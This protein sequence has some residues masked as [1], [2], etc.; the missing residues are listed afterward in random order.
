MLGLMQYEQMMI[1]DFIVHA[2]RH[3]ARAE[4]VSRLAEGIHRQTYRDTELRAR[5][6]AQALG[7]LDV[8]PGDRVATLAW[9]TYRHLELYFA[10]SGSAAVVNTVNPRLAPEDIA[11]ILG[12]AED[13]VLFAEVEFAP[14][15]ADVA[16]RLPAG[17]LRTVVFLC[18][19]H[20]LPRV[21]LPGGIDVMAY[22][23]LVDAEDGDYAWPR[24]DERS[25]SALCYTSGTTGRPKGVL[26]T[27]RSTTLKAMAMNAADAAGLRA[28]DR[29]MPAVPM[30]HVNAWSL[31][32]AA[33]IAGTALV[34]PGRFLD[35]ASLYRLI[36][37]ERVTF[38]CGVP[39]VWLGVLAHVRKTGARFS[40]LQ[41]MAVGGSACPES[42]FD[43]YDALGVTIM[44]AWGMTE[45]SPVATVSNPIAGVDPATARRQ[46]L[47][48]GR[49]L[50][51]VDLRATRG[52][53]EVSWDGETS[54]DIELRGHWI[55][56]GYY[57]LPSG[58]TPDGWFPTGD[59]GMFDANGF[60]LLTDR[61]KD[62]IK[63][64]GE[65]ISSIDLE[66][67]AMGHPAVAEAAVI[68]AK[69]PKWDERPLL[70]VALKPGASATREELLAIYEG[71]V[72]RW[73]VP[74]DVVFVEELP[75]GATGKL[76]KTALRARYGDHLVRGK[77]AG[78]SSAE[79]PPS[80]G[81][82]DV[83][84]EAPRRRPT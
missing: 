78:A 84:D 8:K 4:V 43:A 79:P 50:F 30:F 28:V 42:M 46:R 67:I 22:D 54:G 72:A 15:V 53:T 17:V 56:T 59:V 25:A 14:L 68:A 13:H 69:H 20:A 6:L 44:H 41:R 55:A 38:A 10:I 83:D 61:S 36:E 47:S 65:W 48:Q 27:H 64:G 76:L 70:I 18:A 26:Y 66:N 12:H 57:Q 9:N 11:Y 23:A 1:S 34:M 45:S 2:A 21:A 60:V 81:A 31:P 75:H 35:G 63:S 73:A 29:L 19:G 3:H 24:F 7:R 51:G 58:T 52:S 5:K 16:G 37:D 32:Y 49:A 33:T 80:I 77:T 62:L 74:D 40:T 82:E 71:K 39:S